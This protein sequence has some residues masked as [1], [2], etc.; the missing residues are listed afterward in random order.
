MTSTQ[1]DADK[2]AGKRVADAPPEGE[3]NPKTPRTSTAIVP[4][5]PVTTVPPT[6]EAPAPKDL[7]QWPIER[8][9]TQV[10]QVFL[11]TITQN[12]EGGYEVPDDQIVT[13]LRVYE[14]NVTNLRTAFSSVLYN[15]LRTKFIERG[16]RTVAAATTLAT[17]V[18]TL[19]AD[20]CM[21]ALYAKLRTLHRQI[22]T[23]KGRFTDQPS[24]TKDVE[25]PL[26]F[27]SAI[28]GIGLFKTV[29]MNTRYT[30][31]P[32]YPEST[33]NEG[34]SM[35]D[36]SFLNYKSYLAYFAEIGI[37]TKTIDTRVTPGNAW[38]T[39]R[40]SYDG[41]VYDLKIFFPPLHFNDHLANLAIM[42]LGNSGEQHANAPLITPKADD[43]DYGWHVKDIREGEQARAFTALCQWA[44]RY[45][46]E[47][48]NI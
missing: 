36:C 30:V 27:A 12:G 4:V 32:V 29:A 18:S 20:V 14:I 21:A 15:V 23:Y 42:F 43:Q 22:S 11:D 26:P 38:W 25:I 48:N 5:G 17:N 35:A 24:Y 45:W 2:A 10:N 31:I 6:T 19:T 40:T 33:A 34:R 39:Y 44:P 47:K 37:P 16:D 46:N 3:P 8:L 28:E 7:L 9:A 13:T 41:D 1:T